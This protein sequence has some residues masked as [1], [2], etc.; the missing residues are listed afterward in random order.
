M[1]ATRIT[2]QSALSLSLLVLGLNNA[3]A[4]L[5]A[6]TIGQTVLAF[7]PEVHRA[8]IVDVE[9]ESFVAGRV[10]VV[11]PDKKRVLGMVPTG[12]QRLRR[13]V[14]IRKPSTALTSFT[15]AAPVARVRMC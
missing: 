10:T 5:P 6:D 4:D 9:F 13:S 3:S 8:F 1:R 14:T 12:L 15:H 2:V 11:D 7:P